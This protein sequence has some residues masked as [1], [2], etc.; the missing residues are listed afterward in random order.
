MNQN[1]FKLS[2][3]VG[4]RLTRQAD[5]TFDFRAGSCNTFM[6][7]EPKILLCFGNPKLENQCHT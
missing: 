1:K 3:I 2:K 5:L 4:C 7:P 6:E